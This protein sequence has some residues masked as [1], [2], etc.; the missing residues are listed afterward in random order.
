V[1]S[2]VDDKIGNNNKKLYRIHWKGYPSDQ[3]TWQGYQ[4]VKNL[5]AY[6]IYMKMKKKL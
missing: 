3:D 1:D 5:K 6:D 2:I 4:D